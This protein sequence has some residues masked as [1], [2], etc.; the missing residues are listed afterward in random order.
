MLRT[1]V[2]LR[3]LG[4]HI[5]PFRVACSIGFVLALAA[6][7]SELSAQL[8][9]SDRAAT[10]SAWS[11]GQ[12]P[13]GDPDIQGVWTNVDEFGVPLER[14]QRFS[15]RSHSDITAGD[16]EEVARELNQ[17]R[18]QNPENS[19]FGGL[20]ALAGFDFTTA[21][22]RAWLLIDPPDARIPPLTPAGQ[23]RQVAFEARMRAAP[24]SA[25]SLNSWYRCISLGVPRSMMPSRD[26][27]PYRIVQAPGIVAISYERMHEA[28][29]IP[30]DGRPH[31]GDAIRSY[32]GDPRGHWEDGSLVVETTNFKGEFQMTSAASAELR[33]I[34]RFRPVSAEALEWSVT[35]DDPSGWERPW[36]F[37]MPLARTAEQLFEDACHEGNQTI[38][39]ILSAARAEE[40]AM[41]SSGSAA[42]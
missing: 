4:K 19:A 40:K 34:E 33:V 25:A 36:T 31:V 12:T 16:L 15:G 1:T 32:M 42:R 41:K 27:A 37:S 8:A 26:G 6:V 2:S 17:R 9:P 30:L 11:P 35:V 20:S 18:R 7:T 24:E 13:W 21:P 39:N 23:S 10:R 5:R 29:V 38:R 3:K 28:R 22:S 14:P